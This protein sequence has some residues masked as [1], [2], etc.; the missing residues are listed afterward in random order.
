MPNPQDPLGCLKLCC[1]ITWHRCSGLF[2]GGVQVSESSLHV[3][4]V[5]RG[6]MA[7]GSDGQ[8]HSQRE[9]HAVAPDQRWQRRQGAG[10]AEN[11]LGGNQT[12]SER[13]FLT[14]GMT[15]YRTA[16]GVLAVL[17]VYAL[18]HSFWV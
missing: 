4:Q 14:S 7:P 13:E 16:R 18:P 10:A 17:A 9:W 15:V 11:S 8:E 1:R 12:K 5:G 2:I 3:L 6:I